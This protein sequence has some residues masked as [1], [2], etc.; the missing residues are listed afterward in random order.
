MTEPQFDS[1]TQAYQ[2]RRAAAAVW[3]NLTAQEQ[4][5]IRTYINALYPGKKKPAYL[6]LYRA[7]ALARRKNP[8]GTAP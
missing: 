5:A 8:I 1:T 4:Q 7:E 6:E 2:E 3:D